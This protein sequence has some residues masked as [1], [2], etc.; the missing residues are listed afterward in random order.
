LPPPYA[1]GLPIDLGGDGRSLFSTSPREYTGLGGGGFG[2]GGFFNVKPRT[3]REPDLSKQILRQIGGGTDKEGRT[4]IKELIA[5]IQKTISPDIWDGAGGPASIARL[6]NAFIISADEST[7]NQIDSLLNLFRKRWGTLRTVSLRAYWLPLTDAELD[8]LLETHGAQNKKPK[9]DAVRTF[10]LVKDAQWRK[11]LHRLQESDIDRRVGYRAAVTC[12][13]GQTVHTLSGGNS[14]A[15]TGIE[16]VLTDDDGE[17]IKGRVAYRPVVSVIQEGTVMQI[18]PIA[19][20][21]GTIV[22]LDIHSRTCRVGSKAK[23]EHNPVAGDGKNREPTPLDVV[24]A[25]NRPRLMLHQ[26]STTLR[27]PVNRVI[28]VGGMTVGSDPE[29]AG[30]N[31]YLFVKVA[32]QELRDDRTDPVE[33][34][35]VKASKPQDK[36]PTDGDR[37]KPQS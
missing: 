21:N 5:T 3:R 27:V 37:K 31:L 14:L 10:G 4:S 8:A 26:L 29:L 19:N 16:P 13:N 34:E 11:L 20:L 18:T 12:Y 2:G 7:H 28:L 22:L 25:I 6:G 32:V 23:P 30:V 9:A 36:K 17:T 24:A 33:V 35:A 15:V 1:A